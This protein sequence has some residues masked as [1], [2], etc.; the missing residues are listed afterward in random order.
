MCGRYSFFSKDDVLE[1]RFHAQVKMPLVRHYNAAPTQLLPVILNDRPAEIVLGQWGLDPAW[2]KPGKAKPLINARA[3][4]LSVK[5]SFRD[6]FK[7]RRCL[8]LSDSFFEWDR[9]AAAKIPFRIFLK[10]KRPFAF[11]GLWENIKNAEGDMIPSFTIITVPAND[12]IQSF[13]NRMPVI[14]EPGDEKKWLDKTS[15]LKATGS[16]LLPYPSKLMARCQV[17]TLVNS[18]RHEQPEVINPI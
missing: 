8:V 16:L 14:L 1:E 12:L 6:A 7:L 18:V 9:T 10:N 2:A 3:E 15:D 4:T 13:H 11:A 5:P 17:S